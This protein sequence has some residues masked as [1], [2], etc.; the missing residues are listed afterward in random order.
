MTGEIIS[1]PATSLAHTEIVESLGKIFQ[2]YA[3]SEDFEGGFG[4]ICD[5]EERGRSFDRAK[6]IG[7]EILEGAWRP[8]KHEGESFLSAA[9][10]K[11]GLDPTTIKRHVKI[12]KLLKSGK[13]PEEEYESI[14]QSGEKSLVQV[15][16]LVDAG[17]ELEPEDW[18]AISE[19]SGDDRKVGMIARKIKKVPPRSNYLAITINDKGVLVAHTATSHEEIGKLYVN[20]DSLVVQKGI[21]RLTNCS[22]VLPSIE[23]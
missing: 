12:Q 14:E 10:R 2:T 23:Y 17:Y 3:D 11:T 16:N 6:S 13:I 4:L 19:A 7:F 15:A 1:V 5:L 21:S 18:L 9:V 8:E 22:G 20:S